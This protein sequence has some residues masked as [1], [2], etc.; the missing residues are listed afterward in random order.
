MEAVRITSTARKHKLSSRRIREALAGAV[1]V[2]MDGDMALYVGVDATGLAIELGI[3]RD[4]RG[5]GFAVVHA[6]PRRWRNDE[7]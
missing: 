2:E 3:V 7:Q 1:F 5:A 4:D 6:M